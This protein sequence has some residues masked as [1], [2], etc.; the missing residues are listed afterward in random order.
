ALFHVDPNTG[1]EDE[2]LAAGRR[3]VARIMDWLGEEAARG[4]MLEIGCGPARTAEAFAAVFERVVG[5]DISP[6][7]LRRARARGLPP[8]LV[9]SATSGADR[10]PFDVGAVYFV[11]SHL[12]SQHVAE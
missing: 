4:R 8:H 9:L 7:M 12:V 5:V 1:D 6:D 3:N 2:F 10:E 11:F